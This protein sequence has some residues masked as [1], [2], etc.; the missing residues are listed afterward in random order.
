MG[1]IRNIT[2]IALL[3]QIIPSYSASSTAPVTHTSSPSNGNVSSPVAQQKNS[4]D[5]V[6]FT[7][8]SAV[9]S[10]VYKKGI[11]L[12][13]EGKQTLT[14]AADHQYKFDFVVDTLLASLKESSQF[15]LEGDSLRPTE[16]HYSSS[17]LGKRKDVIVT[18]DWDDMSAINTSK[19]NSWS[20]PINNTT[21][22]RLTLQLQLRYDL[23]SH[24]DQ[25]D[26]QIADGGQAKLYTFEKRD[27][28]MIKTKLGELETIKVVRTD[29]LSDKRHQYFWFAPKYDYLLVKME[30]FEKGESYTLNLDK[31]TQLPTPA[32]KQ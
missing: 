11:T 4:N 26:Y 30:H 17:V 28:E 15:Y 31:I 20:M 10:T 14:E 21:L 6:F 5:P 3:F 23:K 24:R 12:R 25:L 13:V 7:P 16:Y 29:N 22:D 19:G 32:A 8:Y 18:F 2:A 27:Q 1:I 9:Y